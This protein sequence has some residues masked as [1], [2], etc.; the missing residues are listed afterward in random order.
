[1]LVRQLNF[2]LYIDLYLY[3]DI[4]GF[5]LA[6]SATRRGRYGKY[7]CYITSKGNSTAPANQTPNTEP[8]EKPSEEPSEEPSEPPS[9]EPSEE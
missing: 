7:K 9:E 4:F 8:S 3:L 5:S 2:N 6:T 1:M